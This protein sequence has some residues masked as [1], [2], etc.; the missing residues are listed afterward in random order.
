[1]EKVLIIT[2]DLSAPGR[3]YEDLLKQIKSYSSWAKLCESS[4]LILTS[5]TP[6]EVRD[7]LKNNIDKND[8]LYV[9]VVVAPAAWV[10]MSE[11]VSNWI[12]RYL[13]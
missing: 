1:M 8:K 11:S 10:G 6:V 12:L 5:K 9:G 7:H 2:Y 4:Y 13:K 3:N